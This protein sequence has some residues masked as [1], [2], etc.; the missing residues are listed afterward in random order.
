MNFFSSYQK[1]IG[2]IVILTCLIA[3]FPKE[4]FAENSRIVIDKPN[5]KLYVIENDDTIFQAPVCVGKNIGNKEK[6]GDHKTPEGKFSIS[7][8]QNS[9][10]WKHDF[11]DGNGEVNGAYGP[12]FIRL[13]TPK[14]TSIGIHGTCF[15][16]S[17]GTRDSEGCIRLFNEDL[18]RLKS[19]VRIGMPVLILPDTQNKEYLLNG[20][21]L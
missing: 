7:Q 19:L 4:L 5:L 20:T 13:K 9:K 2:K 12:W 6:K 11:G 15:P 21:E 1:Y 17:I 3:I 8:I 16:E 18:I 14:W 10:T